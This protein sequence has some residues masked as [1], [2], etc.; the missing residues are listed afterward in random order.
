MLDLEKVDYKFYTQK[1]SIVV[2]FLIKWL[3][4]ASIVSHLQCVLSIS[5]SLFYRNVVG[6]TV[7]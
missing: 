5:L 2:D 1:V 4:C 3:F 7:L 6:E